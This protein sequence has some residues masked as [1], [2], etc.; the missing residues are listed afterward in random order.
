[1][2][3]LLWRRG[4]LANFETSGDGAALLLATLHASFF[5]RESETTVY[6]DIIKRHKRK[7][8]C[9]IKNNEN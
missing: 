7:V 8:H 4:G 2:I 6:S 9:F 5:W 3:A 1:M